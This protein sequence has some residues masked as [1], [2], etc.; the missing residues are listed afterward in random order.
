MADLSVEYLGLAL[1]NPLIVSSCGI[2]SSLDGIRQCAGLGAGAVVLPSLFE[3]QIDIENGVGAE[4]GHE[5]AVHPEAQDYLAELGMRQGP[6]R[7]LALIADAKRAVD[8]PVI[9]SIN[10]VTDRWWVEFARR[11]ESAGADAL[12]LNIG[13]LPAGTAVGA[14]ELEQR[15]VEIVRRVAA[16]TRLPVAVKIG[17]YF[18]SLPD[19][20]GRLVEAGADSLVLFNRFYQLD[21]DP[22]TRQFITGRMFSTPAELHLPLRWAALLSPGLEIP[23]SASTGVHSAADVVKMLLVGAQVVQVASALYVR[24]RQHLATML[25]DLDAWADRHG[26]GALEDIRGSLSAREPAARE[27]LGRLQHLKALSGGR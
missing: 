19:V 7:Y 18:S 17:P 25:N 9:A 20:A 3:E 21:L 12:E 22:E 11:I 26:V 15:A 8:I 23:I 16:R 14:Q 27:A 10:C 6:E 24:K 5:L 1:K 13:F 4:P 2:T